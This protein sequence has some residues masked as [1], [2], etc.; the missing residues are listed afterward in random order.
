MCKN[1]ERKFWMSINEK[2]M[3]QEES[4][5]AEDDILIKSRPVWCSEGKRKKEDFIMVY[6]HVSNS[7]SEVH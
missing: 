4:D 6:C 2:Y 7:S 3:S 1:K 5:E